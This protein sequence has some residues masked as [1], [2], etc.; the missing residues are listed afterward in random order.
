MPWIATPTPDPD[1]L[2]DADSLRAAWPLLH[3]GDAEPFPAKARIVDAWIA[4]HAGQFERAR[5]MGL[6]AGL[7][8]YAVAH[9]A[10]CIYASFIETSEKKKLDIFEEVAERCERQKL[11]QPDNPA[12][13]YWYAFGFGR[14]AQ[15][16]S[17]VKA[18]AQGAAPKV[19]ASL[20]RAIA[21]A[22]AHAEAHTALG[23]FHTEIVAS[24]GSMIGNLTYGVKREE[25]VR[26]FRRALE[27]DPGSAIGRIEYARGLQK[28]EGKKA[29]GAARDLYAEA[30]ALAPHDA[31]TA[32]HQALA[33]ELARG[34][35]QVALAQGNGA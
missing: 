34:V 27:L 21:L 23:V 5:R 11:E 3:R 17:I 6:D 12:G 33:A 24:V 30:A 29:C 14:Y 35:P 16:I 13:F 10:S 19:R 22:P 28:L 4:F 15:G 1:H 18:L 8:G 31:M 26:A 20:E 32:L 9:K 25:A 7:D 2:H